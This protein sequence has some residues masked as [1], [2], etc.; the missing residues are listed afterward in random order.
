MQGLY[1]PLVMPFGLINAPTCMQHFM[2]HIFTPLCN[3]YPG[4]FENYMDNCAIMTGEGETELH[5]Q[6]TREVL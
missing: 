5:C 6:I 2:N 3:K 4:C 1:A